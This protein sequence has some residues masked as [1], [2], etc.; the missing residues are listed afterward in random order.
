MKNHR[1]LR[2]IIVQAGGSA[3]GA[4]RG[5]SAGISRTWMMRG[6]LVLVLTLGGIAA[7]TL[8]LPGHVSAGHAQVTVQQ[9]AHAPARPAGLHLTVYKAIPRP[10]MY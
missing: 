5:P 4:H 6:I 2:L 1:S 8:T 3:G 10:W 7:A 9:R